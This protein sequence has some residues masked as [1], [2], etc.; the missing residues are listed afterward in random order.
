[1]TA[2]PLLYSIDDAMQIIGLGRTKL[3]ALIADGTIKTV[4]IGRRR[5]VNAESLRQLANGQPEP[6]PTA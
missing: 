1:M 2:Q 3:Y 6:E 4:K 5:L